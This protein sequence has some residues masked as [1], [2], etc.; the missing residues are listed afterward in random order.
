MLAEEPA[1]GPFGELVY[2]L[3]ALLPRVPAPRA[4]EPCGVT[5]GGGSAYAVTLLEKA[6][7]PR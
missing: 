1:D 2:R 7:G 3:T 4:G 5:D 6:L